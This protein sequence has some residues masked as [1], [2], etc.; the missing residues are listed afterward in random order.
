MYFKKLDDGTVI[1]LKP[2]PL[3]QNRNAQKVDKPSDAPKAEG[4]E[5]EIKKESKAPTQTKPKDVTE[6]Q[7]SGTSSLLET[8]EDEEQKKKEAAKANTP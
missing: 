4:G 6:S 1:D 5:S 2:K 3:F 7:Q 8:S